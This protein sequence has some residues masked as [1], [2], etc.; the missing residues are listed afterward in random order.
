MES[1][2]SILAYMDGQLWLSA[3]V[4]K[5]KKKESAKQKAAKRSLLDSYKLKIVRVSGDLDG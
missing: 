3:G 5:I 2:F 1:P 4:F